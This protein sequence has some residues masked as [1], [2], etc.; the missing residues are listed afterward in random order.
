M[1]RTARV[2]KRYRYAPNAMA[3]YL[4]GDH[5]LIPGEIVCVVNLP[6]GACRGVFRNVESVK[7]GKVGFVHITNLDSLKGGRDAD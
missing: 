6:G 3:H 2:G 5:N 1:V 4:T 7:T